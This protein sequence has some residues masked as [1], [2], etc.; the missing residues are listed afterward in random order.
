ML[1]GITGGTGFIGKK[2]LQR[3]LAAGDTVRLLSRKQPLKRDSPN[4]I[5]IFQGDLTGPVESLTPFVDDLDVLYHCAGEV[6][7]QTRM[8]SVHVTGTENLCAAAA[9]KI[10]HW[11]QLS[12]VGVY[13]PQYSGV[14]SEAAPVA[15]VGVYEK[16]KTK[17]DQLVIAA[18]EG[19]AFTYSILRPS[20]VFGPTMTNNSIFQMFSMINRGLFFF[21]GKHGASANYIHADNVAEG[22]ILCG[23][24]PA[25]IGRVYNLSDHRTIES[26]VKIIT[27]ELRIPFPQ[28]RV[29]EII[30]LLIAKSFGLIPSFPL[31][32]GRV[33]GLTLRSVYSID[34]IQSEL[35][36]THPVSMEDGLRQ[37]VASWINSN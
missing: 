36:Y 15:P 16:T 18:S 27:D 21:I 14:V 32:G 20:N 10:G 2:L 5:Q 37:T 33:K 6:V 22:L 35:G 29:P 11:V 19:G 3:H 23:K 4:D 7:D 34:R 17:S 30:A 9:G 25:A 1:I 31:T 8:N 13:G 28:L 12:S 24:N 26:F